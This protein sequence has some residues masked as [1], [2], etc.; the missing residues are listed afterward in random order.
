MSRSRY[1]WDENRLGRIRV[2]KQELPRIRRE[3]GAPSNAA[4]VKVCSWGKSARSAVAMIKYISEGSEHLT[5]E[6]KVEDRNG[7]DR[8]QR[9]AL[10][11]LEYW[12][13][14][15][16]HENLSKE[17]EAKTPMEQR[18]MKE[19]DRLR[20]RQV[21]HLIL[22]FPKGAS[23]SLTENQ[24]TF[25]AQDA[26]QPYRDAGFRFVMANHIQKDHQHVHVVI[27]ATNVMGQ[28]LRIQPRDIQALRERMAQ[29]TYDHARI[30][31]DATPSKKQV[32]RTEVEQEI[33]AAKAAVG[34]LMADE[35]KQRKD[36][37][38]HLKKGNA[39]EQAAVTGTLT[40]KQVKG[41]QAEIKGLK[42]NAYVSKNGEKQV[43]K[44]AQAVIDKN[45]RLLSTHAAALRM[46]PEER[47]LQTVTD[48]WRVKKI[49]E[50]QQQLTLDG[51]IKE[52]ARRQHS[53]GFWA[54]TK[55]LFTGKPDTTE[56]QRR[57]VAAHHQASRHMMPTQ[58]PDFQVVPKSIITHVPTWYA[59]HGAELAMER[60]RAHLRQ[61][62]PKPPTVKLPE[63]QSS[64]QM[65]IN[66]VFQKLYQN[67]EKAKDKFLEMLAEKK[68]TALWTLEKQPKT[69]GPVTG[70]TVDVKP[71]KAMWV[72]PQWVKTSRQILE[73]SRLAPDSGEQ[74]RLETI[75]ALQDAA[76]KPYAEIFA[77]NNKQAQQ[78][79]LTEQALSQPLKPTPTQQP[80][81]TP[82]IQPAP[83]QKVPLRE[84][85]LM[86]SAPMWYARHG[87]Q[88]EARR[89]G[90]EVPDAARANALPVRIVLPP[91][92]DA[93]V[94]AH[95]QANYQQPETAKIRFI[96]LAA[97]NSRGAFWNLSTRPAIFGDLKDGREPPA[98]SQRD[99]ALPRELLAEVKASL[100]AHHETNREKEA[101]T[102]EM[103]GYMTRP[104]MRIET[105]PIHKD[106]PVWYARH[107]AEWESR[108]TGI[109]LGEIKPEPT[110]ANINA[111]ENAE[112]R[113]LIL[114]EFAKT[115]KTVEAP[116]NRFIEMLAE[117]PSAAIKALETNP[118]IFGDLRAPDA[119]RP[120]ITPE[121]IELRPE[122][123]TRLMGAAK[124]AITNNKD[125]DERLRQANNL[126]R[127]VTTLQGAEKHTRTRQQTHHHG[128]TR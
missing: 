72:D 113:A 63:M 57:L 21:A 102:A 18:G 43:G 104:E 124:A 92:L 81:M 116:A 60:S 59:R 87:M 119:P 78:R 70:E 112:H 11:D 73:A 25:I 7:I 24:M 98:I 74:A 97:E 88:W 111:L 28:K 6:I 4:V 100:Q 65:A 126:R 122:L 58:M 26:M 2:L 23:K 45:E 123:T 110:V 127:A 118:A 90:H 52:L 76:Q 117:N 5:E 115:F 94:T 125:A 80:T 9:Q 47:K 48:G 54:K 107:G 17:A 67:P 34:G 83:E 22:S 31:L 50:V 46:K 77:R 101:Q 1:L 99:W 29:A 108:R 36:Y 89:T 14:K 8:T 13:I 96:E 93:K 66:V 121:Q 82:V 15:P 20:N 37:I 128:V 61:P 33:Y 69:F 85:P 62:P 3:G 103:R 42:K 38:E 109:L 30:R 12:N 114:K 10:D 71:I 35:I 32:E 120:K 106:A 44:K 68:A 39:F 86:R 16:D 49:A 75:K 27:S 53:P 95:F 64:E 40:E 84:T 51:T 91:E 55:S 56:E 79:I 105:N 41:L 19:D